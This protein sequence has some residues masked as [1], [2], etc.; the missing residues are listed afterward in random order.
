[1]TTGATS[2]PPHRNRGGARRRWSRWVLLL[3]TLFGLVVMHQLAGAPNVHAHHGAAPVAP[4]AR[5]HASADGAGC[6]RGDGG[7]PE[8]RHGHPGQVCQGL[9]P[10]TATPLA[11]PLPATPRIAAPAVLLGPDTAAYDAADGSGCGPPS[12]TQLSISRT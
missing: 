10:H 4:V 3:A 7:C 9:V 8:H 6:A 1:M 2:R 5:A 12:L 11:P